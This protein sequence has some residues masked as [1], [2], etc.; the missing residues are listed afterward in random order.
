MTNQE[1][2]TLYY[3]TFH[4]DKNIPTNHIDYLKR[5]KNLYQEPKVIYDIGSAVLH[6]TKNAKELW[7][8]SKIIAFE[9]VKEVEDFYKDYGVDYALEVFTD[10]DNKEIIFYENLICLGGNSYYK[11][12]SKYSSAADKIYNENSAKK[13]I[14]YTIDTIVQK[15]NFPLPDFVKIDVQGAEIDILKGMSNTLKQVNH[16][17]VELQHVEYNIGA[18]Q[19]NESVEFIKSLGFELVKN[20]TDDDYFCGNGPD[21]DYHF[22]KIT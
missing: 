19:K 20:D 8:N 10:V 21:A 7:P 2:L 22:I 1:N 6:W 15:N 17:I 14:G 11:E 18:L 16:L 9:A 5:I 3:K 12:N 4:N 13:R